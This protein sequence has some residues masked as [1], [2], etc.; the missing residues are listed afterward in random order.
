[1]LI[2]TEKRQNCAGARTP[3]GK[4]FLNIAAATRG[5]RR[6][7]TGVPGQTQR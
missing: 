6:D 5:T 7:S 1:M 3:D 4:T 2:D